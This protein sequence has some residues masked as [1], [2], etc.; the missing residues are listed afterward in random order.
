MGDRALNPIKMSADWPV[1][2]NL[3]REKKLSSRN[4]RV[5]FQ[6]VEDH[7][8]A[9]TQ[10]KAEVFAALLEQLEIEERARGDRPIIIAPGRN[11]GV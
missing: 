1:L 8:N 2:V 3:A 7:V 6:F 5:V 10:K 9:P 11:G 4:P